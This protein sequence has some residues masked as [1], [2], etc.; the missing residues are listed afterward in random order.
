[1]AQIAQQDNLVIESAKTL[2]TLEAEIKAKLVDC[3]KFGTITDVLLRTTQAAGK[4]NTSKILAY[5]VDKSTPATPKYSI[6][7]MDS[8]VAAAPA[9]TLVALN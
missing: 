4:V 1:M 3:I 6:V 5:L 2:A 8:T 9:A 7:V